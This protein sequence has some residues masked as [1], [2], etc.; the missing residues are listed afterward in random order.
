MMHQNFMQNNQLNSKQ[1]NN[2]FMDSHRE[3]SAKSHNH[4]LPHASQTDQY[5][6]AMNNQQILMKAT[7]NHAQLTNQRAAASNNHHHHLNSHPNN[8]S[9]CVIGSNA[10]SSSAA[11]AA[12]VNHMNN[13]QKNFMHS[14]NVNSSC[15]IG[16]NNLMNKA[17]NNTYCSMMMGGI[18]INNYNV[19]NHNNLIISNQTP[20]NCASGAANAVAS[21][22][23]MNNFLMNNMNTLNGGNSNNNS[24]NSGTVNLV[25]GTGMM[26]NNSRCSS[27]ASVHNVQQINESS[28]C[29][30][31][32][33]NS[34]SFNAS[35]SSNN[36]SNLS[37]S[38]QQLTNNNVPTNGGQLNGFSVNNSYNN[39]A[40]FPHSSNTPALSSTPTGYPTPPSSV[41]RSE[42]MSQHS[43]QSS[44]QDEQLMHFNQNQ[45]VQN[46]NCNNL[47]QSSYKL[48]GQQAALNG[49]ISNN[50]LPESNNSTN[51]CLPN[52]MNITPVSDTMSDTGKLNDS[53][54]SSN[55]VNLN[56]MNAS[57]HD[58]SS[59]HM[60][61][62]MQFNDHL[63]QLEQQTNFD[64]QPIVQTKKKKE[65]VKKKRKKV[66]SQPA[67]AANESLTN[68]YYQNAAHPAHQYPIYPNNC[69]SYFLNNAM[70]QQQQQMQ[71][72]FNGDEQ[73]NN[74]QPNDEQLVDNLSEQQQHSIGSGDLNQQQ[75]QLTSQC[76]YAESQNS[77]LVN[78]LNES[79]CSNEHDQMGGMMAQ[80]SEHLIANNTLE[81][82]LACL[83]DDL[84]YLTESNECM[85]DKEELNHETAYTSDNS[86]HNSSLEESMMRQHQ[87]SNEQASLNGSMNNGPCMTNGSVDG[88]LKTESPIDDLNKPSYESGYEE[89]TL[90]ESYVNIAPHHPGKRVKKEP[91]W[92]DGC[93]LNDADEK[94][95]KKRRKKERSVR[96]KVSTE[97]LNGCVGP[98]SHLAGSEAAEIDSQQTI[99]KS[100]ST[101]KL[102]DSSPSFAVNSNCISSIPSSLPL[103]NSLD[104]LDNQIS[105]SHSILNKKNKPDVVKK[106]EYEFTDEFAPLECG[107][108]NTAI[109]AGKKR[110]KV[111][112]ENVNKKNK[113]TNSLNEGLI[114][115][116]NSSKDKKEE[117]SKS[118]L[119]IL[120]SKSQASLEFK[121]NNSVETS[122]TTSSSSSTS[123]SL[124]S[125]K[126]NQQDAAGSNNGAII[127]SK[128]ASLSSKN[129]N[130]VQINSKKIITGKNINNQLE[131]KKNE[132]SILSKSELAVKS[133]R[134]NGSVDS[135][136]NGSTGSSKSGEKSLKTK[137]SKRRSSE[138]KALTIREGLMR[139]SD[140]VI[141]KD[142]IERGHSVLWRIEGKSLLQ[143]FKPV[144]ENGSLFY[145]NTS[146]VSYFD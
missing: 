135:L 24:S 67:N 99:K 110:K 131:S 132:I 109:S 69:N 115:S 19:S 6:L 127:N 60:E 85:L 57:V 8:A 117:K 65:K 59:M 46:G 17:F 80:D 75:Q 9:S 61:N 28:S 96:T 79:N 124:N 12:S 45:F 64:P 142:A 116:F 31:G 87:M 82:K 13:F 2:N 25:N 101:A 32:F 20:P 103:K 47:S 74:L 42:I 66:V 10:S 134:K 21:N 144:E 137:V 112:C 95:G 63:G 136:T 35:N 108:Q 143:L 130:V 106:D 16:N 122:S 77:C 128:S 104:N 72:Q 102:S 73:M 71:L 140:F 119:K 123:F 89:S 43:V 126:E 97:T 133:D 114:K 138:K 62:G 120:T 54:C 26:S 91:D 141:S 49:Y 125:K 14:Q 38:Q 29:S 51:N 36:R 92:S 100:K 7:L 53:Q 118:K 146:S 139:T 68:G 3:K 11:A 22:Q 33:S 129:Q 107:E 111:N 39:S 52:L 83:E 15:L 98:A 23:S 78:N 56:G 70:Q 81:D 93:S 121:K 76:M 1:L 58:N 50:N 48:A 113:P 30:Y 55:A 94:K 41:N 37:S 86:N 84:K 34:P 145:Q 5:L 27:V 105:M 44:S 90:D 4:H 18:Q 40:S 88:S